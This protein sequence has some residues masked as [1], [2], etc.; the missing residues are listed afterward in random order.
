MG[1][2]GDGARVSDIFRYRFII[3]SDL[4]ET[5]PGFLSDLLRAG[6]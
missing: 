6:L 1:T 5:V 2:E 4:G 3:R